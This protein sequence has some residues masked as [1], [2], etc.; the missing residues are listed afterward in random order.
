MYNDDIDNITGN[1]YLEQLVTTDKNKALEYFKSVSLRSKF[2]EIKN[3]KHTTV[4]NVKEYVE[5]YTNYEDES[6]DCFMDITLDKCEINKDLYTKNIVGWQIREYA[7]Y[8][9]ETLEE[10]KLFFDGSIGKF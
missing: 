4:N 6:K 1:P 5:Q 7:N 8:Y 3:G 2:I 9:C 10:K